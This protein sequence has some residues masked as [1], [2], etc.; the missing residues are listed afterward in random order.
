[1]DKLK[2]IETFV[3]I[4]ENGSL[5][6]AAIRLDRSLPTVVRTLAEL[7]AS[8]G[9]RL[10]NRTTRRVDLTDEGRGYMEHCRRMLADLAEAEA[11]LA[12]SRNGPAGH[13]VVTAPILF[14]EV[15]VA[16]VLAALAAAY[17]Q[18]ALQLTLADRIVDLLDEHVDVAVRIGHLRDSGL[19]ARRVGQVRQVLCA[20]PSLLARLGTPRRPEDLSALP[21]LCCNGNTAGTTWPFIDIATGE[22]LPVRVGGN[23]ASNLVRPIVGPCRDGAGF[24]MFLSYQVASELQSGALVEILAEW[25]PPPLP[26]QIVHAFGRNLPS[27]VAA[28]ADRLAAVLPLRLRG[29]EA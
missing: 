16:P 9:A 20:A 23:F 5:T 29:A 12:G 22:R 8:V 4:A 11:R 6:T 13:V 25:Q 19:T 21:C 14:G 7:E 2:A 18:L 17:P 1:M 27:R 10:F 3:A 24:A 15:Y 26:V 28:V